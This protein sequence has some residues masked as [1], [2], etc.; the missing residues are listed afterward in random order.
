MGNWAGFVFNFCVVTSIGLAFGAG[1]R[2]AENHCPDLSGYY[3]C[4][5]PGHE[6]DMFVDQVSENGYTVYQYTYSGGASSFIQIASDEGEANHFPGKPDQYI[7]QC[8]GDRVNY[9]RHPA[10]E[11]LFCY[12]L[13][14]DKGAYEEFVVKNG[15]ATSFITCKPITRPGCD[16]GLSKKK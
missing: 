6:Y 15:Q 9:F 13:I 8:G 2:A 12:D 14:N 4:G 7:A 5:S 10:G 11:P 1:V 3:M 16:G